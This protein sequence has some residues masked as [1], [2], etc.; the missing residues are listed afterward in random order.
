MPCDN[1]FR[2]LNDSVVRANASSPFDC[3]Q[4]LCA[5]RATASSSWRAPPPPPSRTGGGA[6]RTGTV[7]LF[8]PFA[9]GASALAPV[10][11]VIVVALRGGQQGAQLAGNNCCAA[12]IGLLG[13]ARARC[14]ITQRARASHTPLSPRANPCASLH[15]RPRPAGAHRPGALNT[16]AVASRR[17]EGSHAVICGAQ[18]RV[19]ELEP[20]AQPT[21]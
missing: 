10:V 19:R 6:A 20:A 17:K 2:Q 4:Y 5:A 13:C 1:L 3:W 18:V 16:V 12:A 15:P 8:S 21:L 7:A 14:K 9:G 11:A